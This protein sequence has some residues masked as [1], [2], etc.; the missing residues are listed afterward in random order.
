VRRVLLTISL[1][2]GGCGGDPVGAIGVQGHSFVPERLAIDS[3]ETVTF[4]NSSGEPHTFT[5]DSDSWPEG[6]EYIASGGFS[7]EDAARADLTDALLTEGESF[8]LTLGDSGTYRFFCIP[9][10]SDGM[11]MTI[12]VR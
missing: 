5:G 6:T 8:S 2:L 7:T 3:G 1:L 9:H 4:S 12:V 10:E 11:V